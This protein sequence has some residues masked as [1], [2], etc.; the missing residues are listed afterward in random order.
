MEVECG[1]L[2]FKHMNFQEVVN[3]PSFECDDWDCGPPTSYWSFDLHISLAMFISKEE[4]VLS[5]EKVI[6]GLKH[7]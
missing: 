2:Y 7:M 3:Y 4:I 5:M 6:V 1:L